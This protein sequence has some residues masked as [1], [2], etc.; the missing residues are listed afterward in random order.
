M[1]AQERLAVDVAVLAQDEDRI[2]RVQIEAKSRYAAKVVNAAAGLSEDDP[3]WLWKLRLLGKKAADDPR[4]SPEIEK[5]IREG[6]SGLSSRVAHAWG[7]LSA[8][9]TDGQIR[10]MCD[11]VDRLLL[12]WWVAPN[13]GAEFSRSFC[14]YSD[15]ALC[16]VVNFLL[17]TNAWNAKNIRKRWERL[18][19]EQASTTLFKD[20]EICDGKPFPVPF[21][22]FTKLRQ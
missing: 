1:R 3:P 14:Y 13:R 21:K 11:N 9:L 17:G 2:R 19:L 10:S 16:K 22:K 6:N 7:S 8:P 12:K 5:A 15:E 20:A 18:G 4:L